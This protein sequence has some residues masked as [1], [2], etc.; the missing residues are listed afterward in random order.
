MRG[1]GGRQCDDRAPT[2][3]D[4]WNALKPAE[5]R[6]IGIRAAELPDPAAEAQAIAL[7][8]REALETPGRTAALVTPD[9]MLARRVSALL[10][11]WDI[12]A[13]DSAGRPLS[14]LPAGTL[15][16]GIA[17]AIAEDLAPVPLLALAQAS[18][19]R[20]RG[21]GAAAMARRR[22][23]CSTSRCAARGPAPGLPGSTAHFE[24]D[25]RR[26]RERL[27]RLEGAAPGAGAA[28]RAGCATSGA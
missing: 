18:F 28:R 20:R 17:A 23:G 7:A 12:E 15:L 3:R 14:E 1:A 4:K 9:R 16:L 21:R 13:D 19:G 26:V 8:M 22:C 24:G 11:R 25:E 5:R 2:S 10:R 6:L 27:R